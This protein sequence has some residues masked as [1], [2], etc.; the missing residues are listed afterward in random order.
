MS[1]SA[2]SALAATGVPALLAASPHVVNHLPMPAWV[3]GL[4]ALAVAMLLLLVTWMFRHS[5]AAAIYGKPEGH[6][7]GQGHAGGSS[8]AQRGGH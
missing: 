2:L 4:I 8:F 3:F 1:V 7:S 6:G 5:A